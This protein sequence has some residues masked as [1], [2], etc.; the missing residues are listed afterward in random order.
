MMMLSHI[1]V[2]FDVS[3]VK[4][5]HFASY[6][7]I[8]AA[9]GFVFVSGLTVGLVYGRRLIRDGYPA[10]RSALWKRFF[11]I[12]KYHAFLVFFLLS[13]AFFLQGRG[14]LPEYLEP[15][16]DRP[17][18]QTVSSLLGFSGTI[19]NIILPMYLFFIALTPIILKFI[20]AGAYAP[21]VLTLVSVWVVAQT[22]T[23]DAV[24]TL[25]K[26]FT[27]FQRIGIF[28]NVFAWQLLYFSGVL[29]GY[30]MAKENLDISCLYKSQWRSAFLVGIVMAVFLAFFDRANFSIRE[31]IFRDNVGVHPI[32]LSKQS[33]STIH[34]FSFFLYLFLFAWLLLV[35]RNCGVPFLEKSA[36]LVNWVF[37]RNFFTYLGMHSLQVFVMHVIVC[38]LAIALAELWTPS[39]FVASVVVL[40]SL[41][42]LF[43]A[44]WLHERGLIP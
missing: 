25:L 30:L 18:L 4:F 12:Y 9:F 33:M 32:W 6:S 21:V 31:I 43:V 36:N 8:D 17:V 3:F 39:H 11:E 42:P 34:L 23:I 35:G 37:T 14:V 28:F 24:Q 1:N 7:W 15:Y 13:F 19:F 10:A 2:V 27:G 41:L 5:I 44:A 40:S 29:I 22:G 26:E 16:T 38:Y 20:S